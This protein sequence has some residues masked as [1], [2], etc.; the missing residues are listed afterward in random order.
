MTP[1]MD[2]PQELQEGSVLVVTHTPSCLAIRVKIV[3][4]TFKGIGYLIETK[5]G[6]LAIVRGWTGFTA[7]VTFFPL[8]TSLAD[9]IA[10]FN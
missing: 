9:A 3:H 8:N 5:E 10:L 6:N 1:H 4:G 2:V 7:D